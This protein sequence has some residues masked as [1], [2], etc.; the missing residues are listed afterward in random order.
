MSAVHR[1]VKRLFPHPLLSLLLLAC[2]LCLN[3]TLGPGLADFSMSI[4]GF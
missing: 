2:W 3:N 1:P 4:A